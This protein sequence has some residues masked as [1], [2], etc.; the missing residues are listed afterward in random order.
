MGF[1]HVAAAAAVLLASVS[2]AAPATQMSSIDKRALKFAFGS[3]KVRGVNLGGWF[4]LEPWITPSLFENGPAA[5][6]DG[7]Y[8]WKRKC[9]LH[10]NDGLEYTYTQLLGKAE[11]KN[12]LEAHWSSFYN[13]GDFALM[14]QAGINLVR[15]PIGY[16]AVSPLP[17]DPYVQ[18]AYEHMRTAIDWANNNGIKSLIDLHGAPRSQNGFD[19]S[20]RLGSVGWTQGESVKNTIRALNKIRDD[21]AQHPGVA[22]IELLN[23]PVRQ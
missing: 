19:N 7:G 14:K 16:W 4:V 23:E 11:A 8:I 10:T 20:G 1:L 17:D 6:V 2:N 15:I 13:E 12:R 22:A 5:A 21:F 18:G 3:E 9:K